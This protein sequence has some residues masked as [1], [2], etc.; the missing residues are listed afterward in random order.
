LTN[1]GE[2]REVLLGL[3]IDVDTYRGLDEGVPRLLEILTRAG[4]QASFYVTMGPDRSG[5][6]IF[7]LFRHPGFLGKM[8]RS[9][10]LG[11]YGLR[12]A[13]SGTLL[14]ARPV[15][16]GL[17]HRLREIE[18]SGFEAGIHGWDHVAWH[19]RL[20][21]FPPSKVA[22]HLTRA[23]DAFAQ[24]T[25][26][27]PAGTAAPGWHATAES[28]AC[29]D[30]LGFA[31]ASDTRGRG[32]F[33]PLSGAGTH[34]AVQIPTTLPTL[35]ELLGRDD[36][37]GGDAVSVW[38]DALREAA[39]SSARLVTDRALKSARAPETSGLQ[40]LTLHA[41]IEGMAHAA[42]FERALE[43]L[44][45]AAPVR[46]ARLDTLHAALDPAALPRRRIERARIPGRAGWIT[47]EAD[48]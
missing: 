39:G 1:P 9:N 47:R 8:R 41:E 33:V 25:G 27:A 2:V 45:G 31:Y 34:R 23:R 4:A 15:G 35:D 16:S 10:A 22:E 38:E 30:R 7:R 3:K 43:R 14:P 37:P 42:I 40:V 13:L 26:R 48:A 5:R 11:M 18:E 6:A 19:D 20:D 12:T 36:L 28:L 24:I 17:G 46:F 44:R 29:Q 32:P 21:R